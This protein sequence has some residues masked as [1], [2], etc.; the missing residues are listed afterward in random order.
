M[1]YNEYSQGKSLPQIKIDTHS[2]DEEEIV[3]EFRLT[4]IEIYVYWN[5]PEH[6]P[7]FHFVNTKTGEKGALKLETA[8]YCFHEDYTATLSKEQ[9]K[10]LYD[11]LTKLAF[12]DSPLVRFD[13]LCASW[14]ISNK[15]YIGNRK[16]TDTVPEY[17]KL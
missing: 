1:R 3:F 13:F 17:Y 7:H 15:K 14:G 10:E 8:E 5:D 4:D 2:K 11:Y 12:I 6:T 16:K 9:L